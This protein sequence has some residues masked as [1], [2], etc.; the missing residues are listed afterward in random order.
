LL[1]V[2]ADVTAYAGFP[3]SHWK[4]IWSTH[5]LERL[6]REIKRRAD[7]VGIFPDD[8]SILRLFGSVLSEQHDEWQVTDRRYLGEESMAHIHTMRQDQPQKEV[9]QLPPPAKPR[10]H[11]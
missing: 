7:V 4:K 5:P 1:E 8:A 6:M 2:E 9:N 11:R 3:P 10:R